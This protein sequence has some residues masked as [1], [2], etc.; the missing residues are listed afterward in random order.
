MGTREIRSKC[1][2]KWVHKGKEFKCQNH[3]QLYRLDADLNAARN[4]AQ[5]QPRAAAT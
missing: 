4:I 2:R 3:Q 5:A 1:G